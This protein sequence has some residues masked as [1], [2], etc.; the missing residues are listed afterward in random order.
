VTSAKRLVLET[1]GWVLLAAGVLALFLPGP[2]MLLILS[3]LVV[4]S[5]QYHWAR[6]LTEPVKVKAWLAA[7][8]S[9]ETKRRIVL[10]ALGALSLAAIGALWI[11][12]PPAPAWWVLDD[13]WWLFGGAIVGGTLIGSSVLG[14][15]LLVFSIVR[16][17][18]RPAAVA[19]VMRM[20]TDYKVRVARRKVAHRRLNRRTGRRDRFWHGHL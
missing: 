17:R 15:G 1:L 3:G 10:S 20:Q 18:G 16:F 19:Q 13:D 8:E 6:R 9:V 12:S 4:L 14:L 11:W 2:G 5:T 7:V